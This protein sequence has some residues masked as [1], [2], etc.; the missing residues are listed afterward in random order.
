M[1]IGLP[2]EI[3]DNENRVGMTP[4]AVKALTRRGHQVLVQSGAGAGSSLA[5]EEYL[6]AGAEIVTCAEDAWA[7]Q[8]VVK[9]KEPIASEYQFLRQDLILFTYLHL[10]SD[11]P[12]TD[13]LLASGTTGIAYETVQTEAGKFPLLD[14]DERGCRAYG[15]SSGRNLF[16]KI[17]WWSRCIN[18]RRSRCRSGKCRHSGR[19][20]CRH[21]CRPGCG[22][23]GRTSHGTG[24]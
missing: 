5:D 20:Y 17:P 13:A 18:G 24:Y 9:V 6:S 3:K 22:W 7:A 2:K 1:L 11:K 15:D 14:A 21:Q 12:L 8:M 10:A 4:G 23:L 19:R 16:T